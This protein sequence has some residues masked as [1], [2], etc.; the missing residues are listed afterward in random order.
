MR[1][2]QSGV[3]GVFWRVNPRGGQERRRPEGGRERGEW[4]IRWACAR[5]HLH[6]EKIGPKSTAE[7]ECAR[8]RTQARRED[9]CPQRVSEP[10][11]VRFEDA[12]TEYLEW[13]QANKRSWKTDRDWLK[14]LGAWFAGTTLDQ[15]TAEQVERFKAEMAKRRAVATV[16]RYLACLRHLFSRAVRDGKA[17]VNPVK[18]VRLFRENNA[19]VRWLTPEEET[20]LFGVIPEPDW[21]FCMVALYTGLR[22]GDVL[23][24][25][26]DQVDYRNGILTIERTKHGEGRRVP[27]NAT[28]KAILRRVP[29]ILGEPRFFAGC[30]K[31]SHRFP[32]YVKKAGLHDL[33]LHDL[34]HTFASWLVMAGEDLNTVRELLGHKTLVM[35]QRYAH[36]SPGH[37]RRA[38]ERLVPARSDTGSGT[39]VV[40]GLGFPKDGGQNYRAELVPGGGIEPPRPEGHQIL[41]LARLPVPPSRPMNSPARLG[42]VVNFH[43]TLKRADYARNYA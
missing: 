21:S 7:N 10:K 35:T 33:H 40:G 3:R 32:T 29:P 1:P 24:L 43:A 30:G 5:G 4:W 39:S 8:R 37:L 20:V 15:I 18:A 9:F 36:L 28:V 13:A 14:T 2:A 22:K 31:I 23:S 41:S 16:N 26:R 17:P 42:A 6:R 38:V 11:R 19:R 25:R 12:V 27:M 34:R